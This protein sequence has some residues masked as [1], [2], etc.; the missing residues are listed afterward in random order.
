LCISSNMQTRSLGWDFSKVLL[1]ECYQVVDA[2]STKENAW[3]FEIQSGSG[4]IVWGSKSQI[5]SDVKENLYD[6][7]YVAKYFC[8]SG[9]WL[10]RITLKGGRLW[11]WTSNV[12]PKECCDI[13]IWLKPQKKGVVVY[14][15]KQHVRCSKNGLCFG[16]VFNDL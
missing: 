7:V 4:H 9:T 6:L 8:K 11:I 16:L 13:V 10:D 15:E 5:N 3:M 2:L 12:L 14:P 1:E